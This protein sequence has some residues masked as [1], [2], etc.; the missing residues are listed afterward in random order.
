MQALEHPSELEAA[1]TLNRSLTAEL[2]QARLQNEALAE[3]SKNLEAAM[4]EQGE[5]RARD[6]EEERQRKREDLKRRSTAQYSAPDVAQSSQLGVVSLG[7]SEINDAAVN[8]GLMLRAE[9]PAVIPIPTDDEQPGQPTTTLASQSQMSVE[10][11]TKTSTDDII[12]EQKP[13]NQIADSTPTIHQ[14]AASQDTLNPPA[15]SQQ[16]PTTKTTSETGATP[17]SSA[18]KFSRKAGAVGSMASLGGYS[19]KAQVP[20]VSK[21]SQDGIV[22]AA[23]E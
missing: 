3:K 7:G 23:T 22:S 19:P 8:Q 11:P 5:A 9:E 1:R 21:N 6:E 16:D 20:Q 2:E 15:N 12:L 17:K 10:N 4:L 14:A 18:R 13:E